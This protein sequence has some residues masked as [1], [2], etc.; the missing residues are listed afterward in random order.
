MEKKNFKFKKRFLP[1][2][3][4]EV[5]AEK[6]YN[7]LEELK[8]KNGGTLQPEDVVEDAKRKNSVLHKAFEW[9]K[10]KAS[11]QWLLNQAR[12]LISSIEVTII[13]KKREIQTAVFFST[14][15]KE[16]QGGR[17]YKS[18]EDIANDPDEREIMIKSMKAEIQYLVDKYE[19]FTFLTDYVVDM[20]EI[21]SQLEDA[22]TTE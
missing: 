12:N 10:D 2:N 4:K 7:R 6:V 15:K 8:K 20:Q 9:D 3:S 17:E 16:F 14:P 22:L 21:M 13:K 5:D 1:F 18:I 19:K 11:H